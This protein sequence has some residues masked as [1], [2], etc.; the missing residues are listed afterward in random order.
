MKENKIKK[1]EVF[2]LTVN[3]GGKTHLI[4]KEKIS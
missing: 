3:D 1:E 2:L 4:P